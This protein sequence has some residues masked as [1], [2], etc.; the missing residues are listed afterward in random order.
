MFA[1]LDI[2]VSFRD[3]AYT[4]Y[5]LDFLNYYT[6]S[7]FYFDNL[8][9]Q[10]KARFQH[11]NDIDLFRCLSAANI[12]GICHVNQ[13]Y[14]EANLPGY[15]DFDPSKPAS[16]IL[17]LDF[18]SLY[19]ATMLEP[20]YA[21]GFTKLT[22]DE[23]ARLSANK[24]ET[25]RGLRTDEESMFL[26]F[27]AKIPKKFHDRLRY[28]PPA[29]QKMKVSKSLL[30]QHQLKFIDDHSAEANGSMNSERLLLT[31]LPK[32]GY[33]CY[34]P[35]LQYYVRIG[36][37]ITK[38]TGGYKFKVSRQ[39]ADFI[40]HCCDERKKAGD[41]VMKNLIKL[42]TNSC[43]GF[44]C[45]RKDLDVNVVIVRNPAECLYY[46]CHPRFKGMVEIKPNVTAI[47]LK[48]SRVCMDLP[49][50]LGTCVLS[51]SKLKLYQL[52]YSELTPL[53]RNR[54]FIPA[55]YDTD[56]CCMWISLLPGEKN[57]YKE[58]KK[59]SHI[60]DFSSFGNQDDIYDETNKMKPGTLKNEY[61]DAD[62]KAA[63]FLNCKC[64][65][66]TPY[67]DG[68]PTIRCKGVAKYL[69]KRFTFEEYFNCL[70][71]QTVNR[72]NMNLLKSRSHQVYLVTMNKVSLS[73]LNTKVFYLDDKGLT[74]Y[75]YG[76]Y[77]I[78]EFVQ[79]LSIQ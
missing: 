68:K 11:V 44:S 66:I 20:L 26:I 45:R 18:T 9:Y 62:I 43:F 28:L 54:S 42:Q 59:V 12:G 72:V 73:A 47:F 63:V 30:S 57:I 23:I 15:D 64:Y 29:P 51:I 31:L 53:F 79:R 13:R 1:L 19:A 61:P 14:I 27:D 52:I 10:T 40:K 2:L 17:Y 78:R 4:K 48:P 22:K 58:L 71:N 8:L 67:K 46:I 32:K 36:L 38:I 39:I 25:L 6:G 41:I 24:Y 7:S 69:Q 56:S 34:L 60:I 37:R 3:R 70:M 33:V 50:A 65:A 77:R 21:E 55:Y 35:L 74:S 49:Y 16:Q 76:H 5:G 75:P